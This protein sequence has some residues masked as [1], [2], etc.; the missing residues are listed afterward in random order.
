[1]VKLY[2]KGTVAER[3]H[4]LLW[5]GVKMRFT[6]NDNCQEV[7]EDYADHVLENKSELFSLKPFDAEVAEVVEKPAAKNALSDE[8][9][10]RRKAKGDA[11]RAKNKAKKAAIA[12]AQDVVDKGTGTEEEIAA[13]LEILA[14]A[15]K[16]SEKK[17]KKASKKAGGK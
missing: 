15:K 6:Q 1:M 14:E 7:P 13:A 5:F 10:A 8:E 4:T 11:T 12:N 16:E 9:K 3:S 17:A 2:F